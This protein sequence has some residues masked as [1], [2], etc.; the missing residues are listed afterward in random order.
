MF[1]G[2]IGVPEDAATGSAALALGVWLAAAGL[3]PDGPFAYTVHQGIEM[4][5]P[6]RLECELDVSDGVARSARVRGDVVEVARGQIA[7]P[8][9]T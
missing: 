5:R 2:D 4:G 9:R 3:A 1:A 6:S 7:I 8:A